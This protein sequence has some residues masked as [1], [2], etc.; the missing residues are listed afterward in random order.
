MMS[1]KISKVGVFNKQMAT[2]LLI[3]IMSLFLSY[4]AA[5][6][7][8]V[9]KE[10]KEEGY[11][12]KLDLSTQVLSL[13]VPD[14]KF[15]GETKGKIKSVEAEIYPTLKNIPEYDLN[16][17]SAAM[18][19]H[20]V[21]NFDDGLVAAVEYLCRKGSDKITAKEKLLKNL[22]NTLQKTRVN[23]EDV[24][25]NL[26]CQ[27]LLYNALSLGGYDAKVSGKVK[28]IAKDSLK[29]FLSN[30]LYSKP[31][32]IYTWN[33]ELK[34]IFQ[35]DRYLQKPILAEKEIALMSRVVSKNE[36]TSAGYGSVLTLAERMNNPF[37]PEYC[38]FRSP[39]EKESGKCTYCFIPPSMAHESELIKRLYGNRPIPDKFSLIDA[40]IKEIQAGN[41][42]LQPKENSGW[43]DYK[44][45]A[46]EPFVLPEKTVEAAKLA[47]GENYKKELI[48]LFKA[49]LAL[50]RETHIKNLEIPLAGAAMP[51]PAIK[52]YPELTVEPI[53]TYYLRLGNSYSFIR[54]VLQQYFSDT[55][56]AQS[57]RPMPDGESESQQNLLDELKAVES[58]MYGLFLLT[59]EEIGLIAEEG[60][61]SR[62]PEQ[63]IEDK[64]KAAAWI[65]AFK[66]DSDLFVD[67]RMMVPVFYDIQRKK[68]KVWVVLGYSVK[69]LV[70]RYEKQPAF[71][72]VDSKGKESKKKVE[73]H[74]EN[75]KIA[76]P[77]SAEVYTD[78]ILN[79]EE[80]RSLCDSLKTQ[81]AIL[82]AIQSS[83][84]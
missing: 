8:P 72:V 55:A 30:E 82:K 50:T 33:D 23:K 78:K 17:I 83:K 37:P 18:V 4:S 74:K 52:I 77:V 39:A 32:G 26:K 43:Y 49:V 27:S 1:K 31:I 3:I 68:T 15:S 20:K 14:D 65:K 71:T 48:K 7:K 81:D 2:C 12:V 19:A 6:P 84:K 16:F 56:L 73:F 53:A 21:K 44:T 34:K 9:I 62:K 80:F 69:P 24:V 41:I 60:L 70:I 22:L 28:N 51:E 64:E 57:Y 54:N 35:Q 47:F 36:K 29:V 79:R 67:N 58:L 40:L 76:Y 46:L 63:M 42:S 38:D 66:E 59:A 11:I 13:N 10:V 75:K 61:V 5:P 45:Y 25:A